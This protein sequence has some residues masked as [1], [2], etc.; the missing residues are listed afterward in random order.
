VVLAP[1]AC[2]G[3]YVSCAS[4]S[5][6]RLPPDECVEIGRPLR[7]GLER[8]KRDTRDAVGHDERHAPAGAEARAIEDARERRGDDLRVVNVRCGQGGHDGAGRQWF[9]GVSGDPG[10]RSRAVRADDRDAAA[11]DFDREGGRRGREPG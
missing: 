3:K 4:S 1:S 8:Q 6:A 11:G 9:G 10:V 5:F 7:H 2:A